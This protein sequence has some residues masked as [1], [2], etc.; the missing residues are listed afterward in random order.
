M[1]DL[2]RLWRPLPALLCL[3]LT[4]VVLLSSPVAGA[5]RFERLRPGQC[6][7][8]RLDVGDL[9]YAAVL[10]LLPRNFF[11]LSESF[12]YRKNPP[13]RR[14]SSGLWF[15]LR[16][17]ALLRLWNR[18]GLSRPLN[19]GAAA[20]LYADMPLPGQNG[21]LS[22]V[23]RPAED[24]GAPL[25]LMGALRQSS[26]GPVFD[27]S[28]SGLAFPLRGPLPE[29]LRGRP[30][31][32]FLELD[33]R[34][35]GRDLV[36]EKVR[37]VSARLPSGLNDPPQAPATA[38]AGAPWLLELPDGALLTASFALDAAPA[39]GEGA[40]P[41]EGAAEL[42]GRLDLAGRGL[43]LSIPLNVSG[44][45]LRLLP[46]EDDRAMLRSLGEEALLALVDAARG[47]RLH[48]DMLALYD[49]GDA[50]LATLERRAAR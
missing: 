20:A 15:Q 47:W 27:E 21:S 49:A 4:A 35:S 16:G 7:A 12:A 38:A 30:L 44:G 40:G 45:R 25:R 26:D 14:G 33:A 8:A 46:S 31:P 50:L 6:F 5:P 1:N 37:A 10:R 22:V 17:G 41:E 42:A 18:Y 39:S 3:C 28:A 43:Y 13:L 9:H 34:L 19:V 23:F 2:S 48:G 32:L 11:E 29:E 36:M 24:D